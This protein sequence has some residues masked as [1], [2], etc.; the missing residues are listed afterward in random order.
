MNVK[1]VTHGSALLRDHDGREQLQKLIDQYKEPE[2]MKHIKRMFVG[3]S[4]RATVEQSIA[5]DMVLKSIQEQ[6]TAYER[7]VG[8]TKGFDWKRKMIDELD[9]T[10]RW[11][12]PDRA[13]TK[14]RVQLNESQSIS[15]RWEAL[16]K[17]WYHEE[18]ERALKPI[19]D[20]SIQSALEHAQGSLS[21]SV[22]KQIKQSMGLYERVNPKWQLPE[23]LVDT[24]GVFKHLR[25]QIGALHIPIIDPFTA[26]TIAELLGTEG[27]LAQ[28]RAL[29]ISEDGSW[30]EKEE[31]V[32]QDTATEKSHLPWT[33][34]PGIQ[35]LISLWLILL[36]EC[37]A[38]QDHA[39]VMAAL[40][41]THVEITAHAD[42]NS[43][44]HKEILDLVQQQSK[45]IEALSVLMEEAFERDSRKVQ[46]RFVVLERKALIYSKP[47]SGASVV[48]SLFPREVV[49]PVN[50]AGKWIE[51]EYFDWIRK[52]YYTGWTLKKYF[53]RVPV[54][55]QSD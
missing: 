52:D 46:Q 1:K 43:K 37:N 45:Q 17:P 51:I 5:S 16:T 4:A 15:E 29:G 53:V 9:T 20:S 36:T 32:D 19:W 25:Q 54:A 12:Q 30:L 11:M 18:I 47:K 41:K 34:N 35:L 24:V 49:R 10:R 3:D 23:S 38:N 40:Q 7:I 55:Y 14:L 27:V 48:G 26:R 22:M 6:E 39:E 50:E 8:M 42:G 21:D 2:D 13:S 31:G 28:L 33:Q 44:A